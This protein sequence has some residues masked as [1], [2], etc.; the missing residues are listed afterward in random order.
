MQS[1]STP[2]DSI[3]PV[4]LLQ[5]CLLLMKT[6]FTKASR[7][8]WRLIPRTHKALH[9][10]TF[11]LTGLSARHAYIEDYAFLPPRQYKLRRLTPM[12]DRRPLSQTFYSIQH[13]ARAQAF[14]LGR[15]QHAVIL[16]TR[17]EHSIHLLGA[18]N[19]CIR[20]DDPFVVAQRLQAYQK[21]VNHAAP[22]SS[23][24]IDMVTQPTPKCCERAVARKWDVKTIPTWSSVSTTDFTSPEHDLDDFTLIYGSYNLSAKSR[25]GIVELQ[26]AI[27]PRSGTKIRTGRVLLEGPA[28]VKEVTC[29][30]MPPA[31]NEDWQM[32]IRWSISEST[33][34]VC[35]WAFLQLS[36]SQLLDCAREGTVL[37]LTNHGHGVMRPASAQQDFSQ[38]VKSIELQL[39]KRSSTVSLTLHANQAA[40]FYKV[41][42]DGLCLVTTAESQSRNA[43]LCIRRRAS[44][45]D[46]WPIEPSEM[47]FIGPRQHLLGSFRDLLVLLEPDHRNVQICS[48]NQATTS[49]LLVFGDRVPRAAIKSGWLLLYDDTNR[50]LALVSL[51]PHSEGQHAQ[52]ITAKGLL[53]AMRQAASFSGDISPF[54][55]CDLA[56]L[57]YTFET[58]SVT[59]LLPDEAGPSCATLLNTSTEQEPLRL[60]ICTDNGVNR[61]V[62]ISEGL[63]QVGAPL[64][65]RPIQRK[66]CANETRRAHRDLR[67][68]PLHHRLAHQQA[69]LHAGR[70]VVHLPGCS[71]WAAGNRHL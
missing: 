54:V 49:D 71:S 45:K 37:D 4:F 27:I 15:G 29:V 23:A 43:E 50:L 25:P 17:E 59:T 65:P 60:R 44:S 48:L 68:A 32:Q 42:Q 20:L 40:G 61:K 33:M 63:M 21:S 69:A 8:A 18:S 36:I 58:E 51:L 56:S 31:S 53:N 12:Q 5:S 41:S 70:K 22:R 11:V 16:F 30:L 57:Q 46:P 6:R 24:L 34:K 9:G 38:I 47:I 14:D 1:A 13:D 7:S 35:G 10:T 2:D 52:V 55:Q 39:E 3:Q 67:A 66:E 28:G 26:Y 64:E 19:A 62:T